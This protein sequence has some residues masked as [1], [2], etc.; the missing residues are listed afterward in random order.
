MESL[1]VLEPCYHC[2]HSVF[3]V[4]S[5]SLFPCK[6]F[7]VCA[8]CQ[9]FLQNCVYCS[10]C[11]CTY[12]GQLPDPQIA[13]WKW[14][15]ECICREKGDSQL[16]LKQVELFREWRVG[17]IHEIPA[18]SCDSI[19]PSPPAPGNI[20]EFPFKDVGSASVTSWNCFYCH[21]EG[22]SGLRCSQCNR[23]NFEIDLQYPLTPSLSQLFH[24]QNSPI[25]PISTPKSVEIRNISEFELKNIEKSSS[26]HWKCEY[27][28]TVA[29]S[30]PRCSLCN[31]ANFQL[32]P[33][34]PLPTTLTDLFIQPKA[35]N[36]QEIEEKVDLDRLEMREM[37][38]GGEW[39]CWV[40][41]G[42]ERNGDF[43]EGCKRVN[44][45]GV[46]KK[47]VNETVKRTLEQEQ[48]REVKTSVR[49]ES[50]QKQLRIPVNTDP[51]A[52]SQSAS[53]PV[54]NPIY[55]K[56]EDPVSPNA[57]ETC[58]CSCTSS[59]CDYCQ[60]RTSSRREGIGVRTR[61]NHRYPPQ[62]YEEI[63]RPEERNVDLERNRGFTWVLTCCRWFSR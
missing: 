45:Q 8:P 22:N 6:H 37:G 7:L 40:C 61:E 18:I 33:I 48:R 19:I 30:S 20:L 16:I 5:P 49:S 29:N 13:Q 41:G 27:C 28:G 11:Q 36:T 24:P 39:K 17:N 12:E 10:E 60:R 15:V 1:S 44:F 2:G 31:R 38:R 47:R 58:T 50:R 55:I 56:F 26:S 52:H 32:Y 57:Q 42:S 4:Q 34:A 59:K 3:Q 23:V 25:E 35:V 21:F 43:C 63:G 53:K 9:S 14:N 62:N 46:Q 54:D 51:F